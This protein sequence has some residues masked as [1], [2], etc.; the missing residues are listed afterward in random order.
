MGHRAQDYSPN[1]D[2]WNFFTH[3][4]ARAR[5]LG[6]TPQD[7]AQ[8]LQTLI[9]GVT[10]TTIRDHEEKVDVVARAVPATDGS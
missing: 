6:L 1:G 10:V 9:G 7:I 8:T 4:Q 3:D 5:A 2:A